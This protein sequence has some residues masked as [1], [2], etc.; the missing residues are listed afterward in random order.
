MLPRFA[1]AELRVGGSPRAKFLWKIFILRGE[2]RRREI[3]PPKVCVFHL[4]VNQ[5]CRENT[6]QNG[7]NFGSLPHPYTSI[8][9][10]ILPHVFLH[11]PKDPRNAFRWDLNILLNCGVPYPAV[12][13]SARATIAPL[14]HCH[15]CTDSRRLRRVRFTHKDCINWWASGCQQ[16]RV[17]ATEGRRARLLGRLCRRVIRAPRS[18]SNFEVNKL[19]ATAEIQNRITALALFKS[20]QKQWSQWSPLCWRN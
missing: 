1:R 19:Q 14:V 9:G 2:W 17:L 11:Y 4:S 18:R 8:S 7:S 15:P 10:W 3:R 6:L 16:G 5:Y 12:S 13:C 20:K